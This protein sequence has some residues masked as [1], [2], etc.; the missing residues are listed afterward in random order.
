MQLLLPITLK[1]I[2]FFIAVLLK[3]MADF[4]NFQDFKP[5]RFNLIKMKT[6]QNALLHIDNVCGPRQT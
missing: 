2:E 4:L 3:A 1:K 6:G 5:L